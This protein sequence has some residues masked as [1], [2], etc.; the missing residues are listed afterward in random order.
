L[1]KLYLQD[2]LQNTEDG[3]QFIIKNVLMDGT[4]THPLK[5]L[6]DNKP[7]DPDSITVSAGDLSMPVTEISESNQLP[8]KVG[9]EV[10]VVVHGDPLSSGEHTLDVT[11]STKEFGDI[12]F[13][14][15]DSL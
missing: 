8:L 1:K 7:I 15:K 14:I 2:S 5:L 6:M 3:F 10:T 12:E 4:V 11:A 13:S 9:V